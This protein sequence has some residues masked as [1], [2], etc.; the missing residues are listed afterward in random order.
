[1]G[2]GTGGSYSSP[3][4]GLAANIQKL[5][6]MYPLD[7]KGRFGKPGRG[8]QIV[9]STDPLETGRLFFS[10]L[11]SGGL[12]LP[13]SNGKGMIATFADKSTV[14]FRPVSSSDGSPAISINLKGSKQT[15]YK[16]H[17]VHE[18]GEK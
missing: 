13:L 15:D 5:A 12:S 4:R 3:G 14:V 16:I 8:A 18:N 17:F 10:V 1:M 9:A 11:S 7:S 2:G 6:S